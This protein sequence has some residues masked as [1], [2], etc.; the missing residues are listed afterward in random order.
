MNRSRPLFV[1]FL[2]LAC[3]GP[4]LYAADLSRQ[5]HHA[6]LV[7]YVIAEVVVVSLALF[8]GLPRRSE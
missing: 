3:G 1:V 6:S 4:L 2:L 7:A 8:F 5:G